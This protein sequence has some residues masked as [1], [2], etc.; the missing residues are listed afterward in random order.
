MELWRDLSQSAGNAANL[1][2]SL[3]LRAFGPLLVCVKLMLQGVVAYEYFS[4]AVY[5]LTP[6]YGDWGVVGMTSVALMFTLAEVFNFVACICVS[7]GYAPVTQD[8]PQCDKCGR[9]KPPRAHHCLICKAC[10]LKLDHHCPWVNNCIGLR[11]HR[12]FVLFLFYISLAMGFYVV[13]VFPLRHEMQGMLF[14]TFTLCAVLTIV[15]TGFTLWHVYLVLAGKTTLEVFGRRKAGTSQVG[16]HGGWKCNV[17]MV[18][19]TTRLWKI[20]LPSLRPLKYDGIYWAD[21]RPLV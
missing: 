12:Y 1:G 21:S 9:S 3:M 10:I 7:P 19:G 2:G 20:L 11:N 18:F 8:F 17:K 6:V 4:D 16:Y 14:F 15:L 5:R 13:L